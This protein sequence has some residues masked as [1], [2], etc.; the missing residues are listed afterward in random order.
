M[1][2]RENIVYIYSYMCVACVHVCVCV[3]V[4]DEHIHTPFAPVCVYVVR[5][6]I[7]ADGHPL[8]TTP[9]TVQSERPG[10]Q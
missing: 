3:H 1:Y 10:S 4:S 6:S 8:R 2:V 5:T 7:C 9:T